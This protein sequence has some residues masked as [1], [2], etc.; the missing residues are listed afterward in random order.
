MISIL[1]TFRGWG[2]N[3]LSDYV[4]HYQKMF[5]NSEIII[6]EQCDDE[7][8]L[9]GQLYNI[10]VLYSKGDNLIFA[11]VDIRLTHSVNVNNILTKNN[12]VILHDKV[13]EAFLENGIYRQTKRLMYTNAPGGIYAHTRKKHLEVN[14]HSNCF[15]GHTGE[16]EEMKFRTNS[17]NIVNSVLHL[18]HPI[19]EIKYKTCINNN[20]VFHS[21]H[22]R[23]IQLDG[24]K[25]TTFDVHYHKELSP[26]VFRIG[27]SNIGV[28]ED[29]AY[30]DMIRKTCN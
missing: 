13:Y 15:V 11:D 8:F 24:I 23:D 5:P 16:D 2:E 21:R 3:R 26:N 25:Q 14:G 27:V 17:P 9:K 30:L 12:A 1:C 10:G 18:D 22:L 19:P 6:V 20:T 7:L 4:K 29:F 28:C